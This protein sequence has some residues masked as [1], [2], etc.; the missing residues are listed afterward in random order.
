MGFVRCV[1]V[2][3]LA[4][5]VGA[6]PLSAVQARSPR[7][8]GD[9]AEKAPIAHHH[10][11]H[12]HEPADCHSHAGH[13]QSAEHHKGGLHHPDGSACCCVGCHALDTVSFIRV[14]DPPVRGEGLLA[15]AEEQK[16]G[17][18]PS[19]IERPPRTS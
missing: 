3:L 9:L 6:F 7:V 11:G 8:H 18:D 19:R 16:A 13:A 10:Q 1:L 2:A 14:A 15:A 4:V 5:S 17:N 12:G